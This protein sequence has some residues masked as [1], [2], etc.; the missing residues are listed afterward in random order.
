MG[1]YLIFS[2]L[3]LIVISY[4]CLKDN[5]KEF[6]PTVCDTLLITYSS[7]I[8]KIINSNCEGSTCHVNASTPGNGIVMET[9][10]Q[11]MLQATAPEGIFMCAIR[12]DGFCSFMPKDK[13]QLDPDLIQMIEC[14][15]EKGTPK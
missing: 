13:P 6:T 2:V 14:W 1:R 11:V 3:S 8:G 4:G 5:A 10:D 12:R 15:I 9:F 7:D